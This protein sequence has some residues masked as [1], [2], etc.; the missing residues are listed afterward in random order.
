MLSSEC[1][2]VLLGASGCFWVL[3]GASGCLQYFSVL[4]QMRLS[5]EG[6]TDDIGLPAENAKLSLARAATVCKHLESLGVDSSRLVPHG[7]GA[8]FPIDDNGTEAGRQHNRR[9]EFLIIPTCFA[10]AVKNDSALSSHISNR[11]GVATMRR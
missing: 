6:H 10:A 5:V 9:T 1:F 3:L 7:F 4:L 11:P 2:W 8:A